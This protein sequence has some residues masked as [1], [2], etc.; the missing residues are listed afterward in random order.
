MAN[1]VAAWPATMNPPDGRGRMRGIGLGCSLFVTLTV[2]RLALAAG[3]EPFAGGAS[4]CIP[5]TKGHL[6]CELRLAH[7]VGTLVST[8][9]RCQATSPDDRCTRQAKSVFDRDLHR[10][11]ATRICP[12]GALAG[13]TN[14]E[15]ILLSGSGTPGALAEQN[16]ALGCEASPSARQCTRRAARNL[17][18]L[19]SAL[20]GCR[21]AEGVAGFKG[22][23]FADGSCV[24]DA[25]RG[26]LGKYAAAVRK[27]TVRGGCPSCLDPDRQTK[28]GNLLLAELGATNGMLFVCSASCGNGMRD[29]GEVCDAGDDASCPGRCSAGCLCPLTSVCPVQFPGIGRTPD[30]TEL[31]PSLPDLT[32]DGL[33]TDLQVLRDLLVARG[34]DLSSHVA[35][36]F[37]ITQSVETSGTSY[38]PNQD[39]VL[40]LDTQPFVV[41]VASG[42]TGPFAFSLWASAAAAG[43]HAVSSLVVR[44]GVLEHEAA[45]PAEALGGL[46]ATLDGSLCQ[47]TLADDPINRCELCSAIGDAVNTVGSRLATLGCL[48][49][50]ETAGIGTVACGAMVWTLERTLTGGRSVHEACQD[51]GYCAREHRFCCLF[52]CPS[53]QFGRVCRDVTAQSMNEVSCGLMC[54]VNDHGGYECPGNNGI[55]EGECGTTDFSAICRSGCHTTTTVPPVTYSGCCLCYSDCCAKTFCIVSQGQSVV[56]DCSAGRGRFAGFTHCSP[57]VFPGPGSMPLCPAACEAMCCCAPGTCPPCNC[58]LG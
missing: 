49:F 28:L 34:A 7:A 48:A 58:T 29:P 21:V 4:G 11:E 43:E 39:P 32:A 10:L 3:G 40:L 2:T 45:V 9:T 14:L 19:A 6:K 13:A 35:R 38:D 1:N 22:R 24:E 15:A 55:A 30:A 20:V 46:V 33:P 23:S 53:G 56:D 31:P 57:A 36:D 41:Y 8:V 47:V 42:P 37:A 27:L 50:V 25:R 26:A 5:D 16:V 17:A 44:N 12:D 51:L 18:K 54:T 52:P